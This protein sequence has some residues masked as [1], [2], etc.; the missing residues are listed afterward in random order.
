M[1]HNILNH[2]KNELLLVPWMN[3]SGQASEIVRQRQIMHDLIYVQSKTENKTESSCRN[4]LVAAFRGRECKVGEMSEEA[5]RCKLE[6]YPCQERQGIAGR[7]TVL[8]C[9]LWSFWENRPLKFPSKS[10]HDTM[11]TDVNQTYRAVVICIRKHIWDHSIKIPK[12]IKL[13]QLYFKCLNS[14]Y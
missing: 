4:T 12:V 13:C 10:Q 6:S 14:C 5:K 2:W 11:V 3:S 1:Y 7:S 9:I 8:Y